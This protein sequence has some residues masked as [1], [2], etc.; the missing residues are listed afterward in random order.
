MSADF[1]AR[2]KM[3][4]ELQGIKFKDLPGILDIKKPTFDKR[5]YGHTAALTVPEMEQ[6]QKLYGINLH[7]LITGSGEMESQA[8]A[9]TLPVEN[10]AKEDSGPADNTSENFRNE[11]KQYKAKHR[12]N[13]YTELAER[14]Q[15]TY[16][17]LLAVMNGEKQVSIALVTKAVTMLGIDAR[18]I[19]KK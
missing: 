16:S 13:T 15:H 4:C 19:F 14:M 1:N 11:I 6:L 12:I 9:P 10:T 8:K 7:W 17:H 5:Y 2:L 3:F 18:N